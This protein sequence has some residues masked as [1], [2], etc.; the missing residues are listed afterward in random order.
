VALSVYVSND[1]V[2][3]V[4]G[5]T[6]DAI[7]VDVENM[8]RAGDGMLLTNVIMHLPGNSL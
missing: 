6:E 5:I 1:V 8:E 7:N 4:Y 3:V 2:G